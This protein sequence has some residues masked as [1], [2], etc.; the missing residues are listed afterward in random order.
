MTRRTVTLISIGILVVGLVVGGI[1]GWA[2]FPREVVKEVPKEV[3]KEVPMTLPV[4]AEAIKDGEIDV[5]TEYGLGLDQRYHKIHAT[6]LG[7]ECDACHIAKVDATNKV[8]SAWNVSPQA[9]G[10]VDRRGCLGCHHAGPGSD[11]YGSSGP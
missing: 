2:A 6:V 10:P 5:G 1:V 7:L 9:P 11:L 3:T 8:L 4:L